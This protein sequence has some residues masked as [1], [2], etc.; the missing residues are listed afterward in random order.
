MLPQRRSIFWSPPS[1]Q[2]INEAITEFAL[3][4]GVSFTALEL[5]SFHRLLWVVS[6]KNLASSDAP[7]RYDIT[8]T[9]L[10]L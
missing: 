5:P 6:G 8:S 9:I 4:G 2:T 3:E 7:S 1:A 10:G